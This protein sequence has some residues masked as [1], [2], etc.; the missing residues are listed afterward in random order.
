M[1]GSRISYPPGYGGVAP[2]TV[3]SVPFG[4]SS[5]GL[6]Q[7]NTNF[8]WDN[9]AKQQIVGNYAL[10]T[11]VVH[12]K[13]GSGGGIIAQFSRGSGTTPSNM[14]GISLSGGGFT[15]SDMM[16]GINTF[17]AF[18]SSTSAR[19]AIGQ[20]GTIGNYSAV[21]STLSASTHAT[22]AGS[23]IGG[24]LLIIQGG[25]GTGTGT[26]GDIQFKTFSTTTSG[27]TVQ[28][29]TVRVTIAANTGNLILTGQLQYSPP[30]AVS[31]T[32][33]VALSTSSELVTTAA[34]AI[35]RTLYTPVGHA[36]EEVYLQKIDSGAGA[37]TITT[38]AGSI[39]GVTS[40][41]T[42]FKYVTYL[43]NGTN[44]YVKYNN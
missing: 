1:A 18:S 15:I 9:T 38:A 11:S 30:V 41:A 39:I 36:G 19:L 21:I 31:A 8:F 5:G 27:A 24:P 32:G 10:T 42:Q 44:W 23:N 37:V 4:N 16:T 12:F 22:G 40:L 29:S 26:P 25:G 28:T 3:G 17:N 13:G 6:T 34:S 2:F 14:Y 43:S 20:E 35:T 7:D 33:S